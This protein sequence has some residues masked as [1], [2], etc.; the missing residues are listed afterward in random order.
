MTLTAEQKS[1]SIELALK[2]FESTSSATSNA[3]F[4]KLSYEV[5]SELKL[6]YGDIIKPLTDDSISTIID[7]ALSEDSIDKLLFSSLLI[8][9][10]LNGLSKEQRI[11]VFMKN[12]DEHRYF[13]NCDRL[14]WDVIK[15]SVL[16]LVDDISNLNK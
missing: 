16:D 1:I 6:S 15:K 4:H 8:E 14:D 11:S 2:K 9:M 12:L 13:C 10:L 7:A 3:I 5:E